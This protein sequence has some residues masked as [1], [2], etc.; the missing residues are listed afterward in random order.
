MNATTTQTVVRCRR[1]QMPI[2]RDDRGV[3]RD[4]A[5][6]GLCEAYRPTVGF[7]LDDHDPAGR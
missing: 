6:G 4:P 3:W 7:H 5:G 1:C 2:A